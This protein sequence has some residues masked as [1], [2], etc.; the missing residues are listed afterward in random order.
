MGWW[1]YK[2]NTVGHELIHYWS[3]VMATWVF[4]YIYT[5]YFYMYLEVSP[6]NQFLRIKNNNKDKRT[7]SV[8][9]S[10]F[11]WS[12][13]SFVQADHASLP[14]W[15]DQSLCAPSITQR[16]GLPSGCSVSSVSYANRMMGTA[17]FM[18]QMQSALPWWGGGKM[19]FLLRHSPPVLVPWHTKSSGPE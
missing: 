1:G 12:M 13:A 6:N 17:V 3:S 19:C 5:L 10:F 15:R 4:H 7:F 14:D 8:Y 16:F 9:L 18:P 11:R 2:L